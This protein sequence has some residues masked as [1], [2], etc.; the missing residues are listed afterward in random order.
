MVGI[1]TN[2]AVSAFIRSDERTHGV[3]VVITTNHREIP[4]STPGGYN[5]QIEITS[6]LTS[7]AYDKR[8]VCRVMHDIREH[9]NRAQSDR[10]SDFAKRGITWVMPCAPGA[11]FDGVGAGVCVPLP[12]TGHLAMSKHVRS[13]VVERCAHSQSDRAWRKAES[14]ITM[15]RASDGSL[16]RVRVGNELLSSLQSSQ[17]KLWRDDYFQSVLGLPPLDF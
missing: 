15:S 17:I 1:T 14:V 7:F 4:G 3:A 2:Y 6:D 8:A 9:M 12:R 5:L 16:R 13:T 11:A 10:R